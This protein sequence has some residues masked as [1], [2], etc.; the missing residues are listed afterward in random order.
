L[1]TELRRR[2][3]DARERIARLAKRRPKP[4]AEL[5]RESQYLTGSKRLE[6]IQLALQFLLRSIGDGLAWKALGY[7]RRAISVIGRGERVAW[8]SES[9]GWQAE[10]AA[11]EHFWSRGELAIHNDMTN[12]LRHGDLTVVSPGRRT[13][14]L[15]EGKTAGKEDPRQTERMEEVVA[16][17]GQG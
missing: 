11:L 16:T 6:Q 3:S 1:I 2:Q 15:Y 14:E 5:A 7:D 10:I 12:C 17:L 8:L 9:V 4:V 13:V